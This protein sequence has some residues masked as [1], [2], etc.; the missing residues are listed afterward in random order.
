MYLCS[1]FVCVFYIFLMKTDTHTYR[2]WVIKNFEMY[3]FSLLFFVSFCLSL[4]LWYSVLDY[5]HFNYIQGGPETKINCTMFFPEKKT[6]R[7]SL[8]EKTPM[9]AILVNFSSFSNV[10]FSRKKTLPKGG[11]IF[12]GRAVFF[13]AFSHESQ[14]TYFMA[15][16]YVWL[17][18]IIIA[19]PFF[20]FFQYRKFSR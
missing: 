4:N 14:N 18:S 12:L 9:C 3:K 1:L 5:T 15:F 11:G 6:L 8:Y 10:F 20:W 7:K 17:L 19:Y 2:V 13:W 16:T